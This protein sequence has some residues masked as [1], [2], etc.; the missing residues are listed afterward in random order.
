MQLKSLTILLACIFSTQAQL[1][2]QTG[3]SGGAQSCTSVP[4]LGSPILM[5]ASA[6][7]YI[8]GALGLSNADTVVKYLY[9][10]AVPPATLSATSPATVIYAQPAAG[11]ASSPQAQGTTANT[12]STTTTYRLVFSVTDYAGSKYLFIELGI[13]PFGASDVEINRFLLTGKLAVIKALVDANITDAGSI[14]CADAKYMYASFDG[15]SDRAAVEPAQ[16]PRALGILNN[17]NLSTPVSS[18]NGASDSSRSS[19]DNSTISPAAERKACTQKNFLE[20]SGFFGT[21]S[22]TN[23]SAPVDLIACVYDKPS[24]SAILLGCT[25]NTVSSLQ[26]LFNDV[27]DNGTSLSVLAGNPNTPASAITTI[28]LGAADRIVFTSYASSAAIRVQTFD[29]RN[30][31]LSNIVCGTGNSHPQNLIL[32][33]Q[34]FLGLTSVTSNGTIASFEVTQYKATN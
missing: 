18:A 31:Q 27:G 21:S 17:T 1:S 13:S 12:A 26:L 3:E 25:N 30:V 8:E 16:Q 11:A 15:S 34:D 6:K 20:T 29:V 10:A 9:F 4:G 24:V 7:K 2:T 22:S 19:P 23:L 28:S 5:L 14:S 33:A 32:R